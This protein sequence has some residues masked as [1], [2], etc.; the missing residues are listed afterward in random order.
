M[1]AAIMRLLVVPWHVVALQEPSSHLI[2][3]AF[4]VH[5][6]ISQHEDCGVLFNKNTFSRVE[7]R[8]VFVGQVHEHTDWA[9]CGFCAQAWFRRASTGKRT[10]VQAQE[11][12]HQ[13][14]LRGP[15]D[16]EPAGGRQSWES[17][18]S[19]DPLQCEQRSAS[20]RG[21]EIVRSTIHRSPVV[22]FENQVAY[23]V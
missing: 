9:L 5:I 7:A 4:A 11:R 12:G 17:A 23:G 6:Q 10:D 20:R 3:D 16:C 8:G 15:R 19:H 1:P 13:F 22:S 21:A 2:F 18:P 14:L